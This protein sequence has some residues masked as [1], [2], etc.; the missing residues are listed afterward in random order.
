MS[1]WITDGIVFFLSALI[2]LMVISAIKDLIG[3]LWRKY[4]DPGR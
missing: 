2:I 4:V 1:E 3:F